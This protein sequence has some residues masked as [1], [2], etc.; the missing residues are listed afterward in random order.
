MK[1]EYPGKTNVRVGSGMGAGLPTKG[2][3]IVVVPPPKC[4]SLEVRH[5]EVMVQEQANELA[6]VHLEVDHNMV[7]A[8]HDLTC[9]MGCM[10]VGVLLVAGAGAPGVS[11]G[12]GWLGE[13]EEGTSKEKGKGKERAVAEDEAEGVIGTMM[14]VMRMAVM[15]MTLLWSI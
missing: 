12:V 6:E 3:P 10:N 9:A 15:M 2:W 14:A 11:V 4:E 8:M 13:H 5:Q 7:C 1:C